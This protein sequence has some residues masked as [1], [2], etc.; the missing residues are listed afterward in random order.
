MKEEIKQRCK[1]SLQHLIS[2]ANKSHFL[3]LA[4]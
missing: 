2:H 4:E 1:F 3:I